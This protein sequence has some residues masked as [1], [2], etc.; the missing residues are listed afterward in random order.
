MKIAVIGSGAMGLLFGGRLALKGNDVTMIDV[1]PSVIEKLNKD[2]L[3]LDF[4]DGEH[5]IPIKA[6]FAKDMKEKVDLAIL[7]TKTIY[8]ESALETINY[9]MDENS[10]ILTLQNGIGNIELISKYVN[11]D[12]V[13]VGVTN[14]PSDIIGLGH[15]SSHGSGYTKVMSANGII[16]DTLNEI[17]EIFIEA[18]LNSEIVPDVIAAIWEKVAFNAAINACT[19]VCRIPCG[20]MAVTEEGK[21]LIYNIAKETIAVANGFGVNASVES[22][23][24]SLNDTFVVHKDHF[25]SM[26]ADIINKRKTE[27]EF[28][29]GGIVKK[30]KEIKMATPYNETLFALIKTIE[31]TYEMQAK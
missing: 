24:K 25:T 1:V 18:G 11:Y 19:A 17:N 30:A 23:L 20:G 3:Q 9:F 7:F 22:V 27:G 5:I 12:K 21:N 26:S 15:V 28:I 29:N 6:S 2:G 31:N 13:L 10:Y 8:S 14:F 16:S 4:D